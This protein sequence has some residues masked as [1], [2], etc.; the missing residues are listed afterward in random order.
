MRVA[1]H[2]EFSGAGQM[3]FYA[4]L[5]AGNR[6]AGSP[7]SFFPLREPLESIWGRSKLL[8]EADACVGSLVSD[9][10]LGGDKQA[11][12]RCINLGQWSKIRS[13]PTV[14]VD[15]FQI[16]NLA[17]ESLLE[18]GAEEICIFA[19]VGQWRSEELFRGVR[20]MVDH[21]ARIQVYRGPRVGTGAL[22]E[23]LGTLRSDTSYGVLTINDAAALRVIEQAYGREI[24]I[25]KNLHVVGIGDD[26]E[27]SVL[28]P[29]AIASV[30][31]PYHSIGRRV[32]ELLI[33]SPVSAESEAL[34]LPPGSVIRRAS[35]EMEEEREEIVE[36]A[37][38]LMKRS[39]RAPYSIQ[40]LS[41]TLGVSRRGLE[42]KFAA[43]GLESPAKSWM[44]FRIDEAKRLLHETDWRLN[45]IAERTGFASQQ[46]FSQ[47]FKEHVGIPARIWRSQEVG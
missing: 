18:A 35:L 26:P 47:A 2:S 20:S 16:G 45:E 7:I 36:R 11:G 17:A 46:R 25:G 8:R 27:A 28:S 4:G 10:W 43:S 14:G 1:V 19:P 38:D 37:L 41:E 34:L 24:E 30:P 22:G 3:A 32:A 12:I 6:A 13:V 42:L 33:D 29:V 31:I 40:E 39:L 23:W 9:R 44:R 15:Y 21:A 5:D